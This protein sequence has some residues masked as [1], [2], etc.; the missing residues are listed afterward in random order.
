MA[1][2]IAEK[3]DKQAR[4]EV[5]SRSQHGLTRGRL[6]LVRCQRYD[7]DD[8]ISEASPELRVSEGM[9]V[10]VGSH[11]HDH[12]DPSPRV[13]QRRRQ[14]VE[15]AGADCFVCHQGEQLLELVDHQNEPGVLVR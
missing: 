7:V 6:E 9:A 5:T 10:E 3:S 15:E 8:P 13:V 1:G 11:G 14:R 4:F 12:D 2:D